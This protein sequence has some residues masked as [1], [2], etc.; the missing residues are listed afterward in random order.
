V[1]P[2]MLS[3]FIIIENGCI[4]AMS[5]LYDTKSISLTNGLRVFIE[6][7]PSR[8]MF[9]EESIMHVSPSLA[10]KLNLI[11]L[12]QPPPIEDY[13]SNQVQVLKSFLDED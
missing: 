8:I 13:I 9:E 11:C 3:K 5:S 2:D 6:Q 1:D 10:S 7:L 4:E 12:N